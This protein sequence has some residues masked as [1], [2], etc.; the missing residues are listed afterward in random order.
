MRKTRL[1]QPLVAPTYKNF[2]EEA[3]ARKLTVDSLRKL[4]GTGDDPFPLAQAHRLLTGPTR[5][6]RKHD[7][8]HVPWRRVAVLYSS[9]MFPEQGSSTPGCLECGRVVVGRSTRKFCSDRCR[10]RYRRT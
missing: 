8:D 1:R 6:L 10:K 3:K 7:K 5:E 4:L 2:R 9:W